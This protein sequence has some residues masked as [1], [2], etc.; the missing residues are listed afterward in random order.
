MIFIMSCVNSLSAMNMIA[1][2][3]TTPLAYYQKIEKDNLNEQV[4][5]LTKAYS[6]Y[7]LN[8]KNSLK[9]QI[10]LETTLQA[11]FNS[12]LTD[13]T[14]FEGLNNIKAS[15]IS[16]IKGDKTKSNGVI[17][18]NDKDIT[19]FEMYT[20]LNDLYYYMIPDFSKAYLKI[21][22]KNM[23]GYTDTSFTQDSIE[24]YLNDPISE[25]LLNQLMKKYGN[26]IID[27]IDNVAMKKNINVNLDGINSTY[28]RLTVSINEKNVLEI[29][30]AILNA[31]KKDTDLRNLF[32]DL[33]I[34]TKSEYD[35]AIKEGLTII[36]D[37]LKVMK[38][39]KF[40]GEKVFKMYLWLNSKGEI[41]GRSISTK[42]G[43]E[44]LTL[45]YRTTKSGTQMGVEAWIILGGEDILRAK[46]SLTARL[47]G[48]SGDIKI[49]L[50]DLIYDTTNIVNVKFKDVKYTKKDASNY[51]NG[52]FTISSKDLNG[53]S[54]NINCKG[55]LGKQDIILD[56]LLDGESITSISTTVKEVPFVDF[57]L[58]S[59]PDKIYDLETQY[60]DYIQGADI[61]GFLE[62]I[63]EKSD[64]EFIDSYI[65]TIL[66]NY[67]VE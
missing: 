32:L 15:M 23:E 63:K 36:S 50:L 59:S 11:T 12:I 33:G 48:I 6:D 62:G 25:D 34:C 60:N 35:S 56:M 41:A 26:I 29:S 27:N 42:L 19:S 8:Y 52:N 55:E 49:A 7:I 38:Q 40:N 46:G 47:T 3:A 4:D 18:C 16:M 28:S 43:G 13:E 1:Q 64:L 30:K 14:S 21:D 9:Q 67:E 17:S 10:G 65:D 2:A 53:L 20:T 24:D 45:G 5:I 61:K 31:A 57:S 54:L 22:V 66:A 39:E 44:K 58:P 37:T 51:I